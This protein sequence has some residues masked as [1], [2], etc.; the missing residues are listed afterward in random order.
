MPRGSIIF[1]IHI[2]SSI[3][4]VTGKINSFESKAYISYKRSTKVLPE[5]D[6][7]K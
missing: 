3:I 1:L 4:M 5:C 7:H 2:I 6:Y